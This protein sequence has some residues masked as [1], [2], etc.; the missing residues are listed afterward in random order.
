MQIA[1][2]YTSKIARLRSAK[3]ASFPFMAYTINNC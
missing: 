2:D 1:F 3:Y